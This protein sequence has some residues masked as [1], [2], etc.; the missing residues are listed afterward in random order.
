[1]GRETW[2]LGAMAKEMSAGL[3]LFGIPWVGASA[4]IPMSCAVVLERSSVMAEAMLVVVWHDVRCDND[5]SSSTAMAAGD[6]GGGGECR[7]EVEDMGPAGMCTVAAAVGHVLGWEDW[8]SCLRYVSWTSW[9]GVGHDSH[10]IRSHDSHLDSHRHHRLRHRRH[11]H[12]HCRLRHYHY[13]RHD[14]LLHSRELSCGLW[15]P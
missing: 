9:A 3:P 6:A 4:L 11:H 14:L 7:N 8:T 15:R 1:M 13:C 5:G 2:K 12:L 10:Y